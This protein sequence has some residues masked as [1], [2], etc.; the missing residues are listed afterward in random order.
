[1]TDS[2]IIYPPPEMRTIIEKTANFVA[3]YGVEFEAKALNENTD[4]L[5]F[6]KA[7]NPYRAFYEMRL[8]ALTA[9]DKEAPEQP[10]VPA[11]LKQIE[12]EEKKNK[13]LKQNKKQKDTLMLT[14][15]RTA[16][17]GE[18]K[19]ELEAPED[20]KYTVLQPRVA[21]LDLDIIKI[22]AQFVARNGGK[23]LHSLS[24][25]EDNNPQFEFLKPTCHLFIFFTKL[26]DAY[27]KILAPKDTSHVNILRTIAGKS[28][29]G[30]NKDESWAFI[31][32]KARARFAYSSNNFVYFSC[33]CH[34]YTASVR[35]QK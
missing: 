31:M 3:T 15:G 10:P 18:K 7:D 19:Q 6:L 35:S 13:D 24:K 14:D 29:G 30:E 26:C 1:M 32:D 33:H 25:R 4:K 28:E 16:L 22:T 27:T 21:P 34:L 2:D 8:K 12:E 20:D 9:G 17:G 23:F 11:G 5:K